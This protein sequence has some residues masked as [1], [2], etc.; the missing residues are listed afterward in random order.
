M[1]LFRNDDV[2]PETNVEAFKE[3]CGIFHQYGYQ[4]L[5]G[6]TIFGRTHDRIQENGIC[7]VYPG[8]E[9]IAEM[10]P[11]KVIELSR[12]SY[13]GDNTPL[14]RFLNSIPDPIALHG[15]YHFDFTRLNEAEQRKTIDDGLR[16]LNMLFPKKDIRDFIPPF[17]K[18]NEATERICREFNLALHTDKGVHLESMIHHGDRCNLREDEEYRYHHHRFYKESAFTHYDLSLRSLYRFFME[19]HKIRPIISKEKYKHCVEDSGAQSWYGYAY[20]N[21]EKLEQC[22]TPYFW[23]RE[24]VN[25]D[26]IIAETGCGAGGVLHMLWHEGFTNLHGY[27]LDLKAIAAGRRISSEARSSIS[28]IPKDC[29]KNLGLNEFDVILGMNWIYLLD[30]FSLKDFIETHFK[31]L[32]QNGYFIFDTIND[33]FN[34]HPLNMYFTQDWKKDE[35]QRRSSEYHERFSETSVINLMHSFSLTHIHTFSVEYTIP[36]NVYIFQKI[37]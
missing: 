9:P 10:N 15:P 18:Y 33:S 29:T 1:P 4:Q 25:R 27:D 30:N 8:E 20:N 37:K 7:K 19:T 32:K 34:A 31:N 28:F 6:V 21:F 2:S 12:E 14:I 13:I 22:Y 35:K 16:I 24:N 5:H 11:S 26:K 23:I 36:R 3:F 17:N